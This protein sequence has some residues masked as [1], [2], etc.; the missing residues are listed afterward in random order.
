[1]KSIR[2]VNIVSAIALSVSISGCSNNHAEGLSSSGDQQQFEFNQCNI[3]FNE[4]PLTLGNSISEWNQTLGKHDRITLNQAT[5]PAN[6]Y[7]YDNHGVVL[8]SNS[9][10]ISAI[11]LFYPPVSDLKYQTQA[12]LKQ[13]TKALQDP[14]FKYDEIMDKAFYQENVKSIEA[15]LSLFP[16]HPFQKTLLLDGLS[17]D[18]DTSMESINNSRL[19]DRAN[20]PLFKNQN[21]LRVTYK[22]DCPN[23]P[24]E[25]VFFTAPGA[26]KKIVSVSMRLHTNDRQ[27]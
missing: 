15:G 11:T 27:P 20:I 10:V 25:L 16:E 6:V 24:Q 7:I 5:P 22:L 1:M 26:P 21:D 2:N 17:I 12:L 3:S 14:D 8:T 4:Q 9:D 19:P 13:F 23:G 18:P